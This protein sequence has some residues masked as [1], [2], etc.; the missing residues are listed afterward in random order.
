MGPRCSIPPV[1]CG[2]L[3]MLGGLILLGLFSAGCDQKTGRVFRLG[4][5]S[6][7]DSLYIIADGFKAGMTELGYAEGRRIAYDVRR[8][9]FDPAA[10][11]LAAQKFVQDKV[12]L[13]FAFPTETAFSAKEVLEGTN[14]PMVFAYAGVEGSDLVRSV[15]EPGGNITGLRYPGPEMIARRLEL[16]HEIAPQVARAWIAYQ[17]DYPNNAP[18]LEALRPLAASMHIGLTEIPAD[19]VEAL[20]GELASRAQMVV[21]GRDAFLLMPD[22]LNHSPDGWGVIRKFAEDHHM[23]IA[24]SFLYTVE[25]GAL[26]GNCNDL[27]D[28]GRRTASLA[29]RILR[30]VPAGTIPVITP[31]QE[32]WINFRRAQDFG[33]SVPMGMLKMARKVIR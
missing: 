5:L 33:L 32:L 30:G 17:K 3:A 19:T 26:F 25:E 14:I 12:D 18:A 1:S 31:E 22:L 15:R 13:V 21:P 23:P 6:G 11:K 2:L 29:D 4:I 20:R 24:G 10:E 7:S 28:V 8:F 16:L 9:N 27:F